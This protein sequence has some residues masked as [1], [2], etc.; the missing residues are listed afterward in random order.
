MIHL[1]KYPPARP[2]R[3]VRLGLVWVGGSGL[4]A[5]QAAIITSVKDSAGASIPALKARPA[6]AAAAA[7]AQ[8]ALSTATRWP[9]ASAGGLLALGLAASFSLGASRRPPGADLHPKR[10]TVA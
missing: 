4:P 5:A 7:D 1:M 9:A 8:R 10:R 6:T 3:P 2:A